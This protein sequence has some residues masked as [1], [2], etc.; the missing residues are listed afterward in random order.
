[1]KTDWQY[2]KWNKKF[3]LSDLIVNFNENIENL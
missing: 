2:K 3:K 1:M